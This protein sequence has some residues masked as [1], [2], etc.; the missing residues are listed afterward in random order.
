MGLGGMSISTRFALV[1]L[2]ALALVGAAFYL[3]LDR[4]YLNELKSQAETVADNVDA[5]GTWVAQYGRVWVK[6][7]ARSY[8]GHLPLLQADDG[9]TGTPGALKTVN[10]Y[11]K[12]P[13]L[14]QREFSEV[15]ARSGSPAQFRLTSHNVMNPGNAPD[16][17]ERLALQR[18]RQSGLK[19][20]FEL[21]DGGFRYAR[22]VYHKPACITCHGDAD[23]APNDVKVRYGT[24][25]GFGFRT[26]DVAGIISV[27]LPARSFWRLGLMAVGGGELA[28]IIAAFLIAMLF[29]RFAV[30]RPVM[31]L[32]EASHQISLGQPANLGVGRIA[33]HSRNE[34]HQLT[35][36]IDRLRRS[37]NIAMRKL[38]EDK[39]GV[40]APVEARHD[41]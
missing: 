16:V 9:V 5:F 11:S 37:I 25:N 6:D 36:A 26:G 18:I 15:I 40:E 41:R 1:F 33:R 28:I 30:V 32:T 34:T 2:L 27:T 38:G 12:N 35:L 24:A 3:I 19:E 22:T 17:F 14:A 20:Y 10:F 7:D 21:T 31:R 4:I 8:L 23:R 29:V 39:P 13:A